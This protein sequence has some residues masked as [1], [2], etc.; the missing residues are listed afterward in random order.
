M[1]LVFVLAVTSFAN[2]MV[3]DFNGVSVEIKYWTGTGTNEALMVVDW[4]KDISLAF[5]YKW[6]D[7]AMVGDMFDAVDAASAKFYKEWV[8]G[9]GNSAIFGIGYD[10]DDDGFYKSDADDYY[11]EGWFE[12]GFWAEVLSSDGQIWNWGNGIRS[13]YI[14]NGTWVGFS[15]SPEFV[16]SD[17]NPPIIPEPTTLILLGAGGLLLRKRVAQRKGVGK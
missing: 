17:P 2:G 6:N 11:E 3:Y 7:S 5:G 15:W 1:S 12:N 9:E 14:Y 16:Y 4:Q 8:A 13:D 10:M